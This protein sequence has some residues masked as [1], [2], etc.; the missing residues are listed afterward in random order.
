V[1]IGV[2]LLGLGC[3][4][5]MAATPRAKKAGPEEACVTTLNIKSNQSLLAEVRRLGVTLRDFPQAFEA[6]TPN[7]EVH[8]PLKAGGTGPGGDPLFWLDEDGVPFVDARV[9]GPLQAVS[10]P[11]LSSPATVTVGRLVSFPPP[12]ALTV[13]RQL[14]EADVIGT[15]VHLESTLCL[16]KTSGGVHVTGTHTYVTDSDNTDPLDFTVIID[17]TGHIRVSQG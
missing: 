9:F 2:F 8:R 14:M 4:E 5:A 11:S 17:D 7:T 1:V 3:S 13:I 15:Y 16:R 10:I 12:S 6:H